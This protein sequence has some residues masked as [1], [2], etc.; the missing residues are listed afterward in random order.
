MI[1]S[2]IWPYSRRVEI[3]RGL[4]VIVPPTTEPITLEVA[5]L[6]LR[7]EAE[8]SPPTHPDDTLI[9]GVYLPAARESC[10]QYVGRA[11][12]PQTLE[13]SLSRFPGPY[14]T[15]G[16]DQRYELPM[17][18]LIGV[19][20]VIYTDG[21]GFAQTL[22]T[23]DYGVDLFGSVIQASDGATWPTVQT[24]A[25]A[26]VIRYQAGYALDGDSP[27][28]T[29]LPAALKAAMLLTLGHLYENRETTT[30]LEIFELPMGVQYLLKPYQIR[31]PM[32]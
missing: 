21:D 25:N 6:H 1:D 11:L 16:Y 12:A 14:A 3:R 18:P 32:A 13:V 26:V 9:S 5:R 10:E 15:D 7:L 4:R 29:P 24:V 23:V 31:L 17:A 20:S 19:D 8:G 28:G 30:P 2:T 22:A 27:S